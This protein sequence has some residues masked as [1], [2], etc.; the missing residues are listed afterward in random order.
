MTKPQKIE[1]GWERRFDKKFRGEVLIQ[2]SAYKPPKAYIMLR[3]EINDNGEEL[4]SFI[5]TEI[6]KAKAEAVKKAD[7]QI[8]NLI[9]TCQDITTDA[10]IKK[11][12]EIRK[13]L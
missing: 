10:L 8:A 7:S 1:G 2:T 13:S 12:R 3:Q 5:S 9:A 6:E 11:L 4:K